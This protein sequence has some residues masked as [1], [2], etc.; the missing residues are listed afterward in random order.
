MNYVQKIGDCDTVA[1]TPVQKGPSCENYVRKL[2]EPL[3]QKVRVLK[4]LQAH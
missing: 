2:G 1:I 3:I 4:V